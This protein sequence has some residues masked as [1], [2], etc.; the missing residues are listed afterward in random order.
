MVTFV[1]DPDMEPLPWMITGIMVRF[2]DVQYEL[3]SGQDKEWARSR[4]LILY[5]SCLN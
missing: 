4:E 2:K 3:T 1:H 5:K